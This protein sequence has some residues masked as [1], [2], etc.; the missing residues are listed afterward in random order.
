MRLL[1]RTARPLL[2]V[3][4][5]LVGL[6]ALGG[7]YYGLSGAPQVPVEWLQGSPFQ[8]YFIPSL[9]LLICVGGSQFWAFF[10][11][12]GKQ[13]SA[14]IASMMAGLILFSWI[15]IQV[16]IIGFVSWL[17]PAMTLISFCIFVMANALRKPQKMELP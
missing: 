17:Q 12:L 3:V 10:S 15:A 4:H 13:K 7:G 6:N 9:I 8:S 16:A 5:G 11:F 14:P 1:E 2:L